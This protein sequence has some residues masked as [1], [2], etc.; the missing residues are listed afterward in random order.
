[1]KGFYIEITNNLLETKHRKAMKES[2]WLFMWLLDK[3]T[4]ISEEGIGKV[5]GGKPITYEEINKELGISRPTYIR[6][7]ELLKKGEYIN[8]L[9]TPRGL[10]F[11]INKPKK[12]FGRDVS[13]MKQ[14]NKEKKRSD[15]SNSDSDVSKTDSEVSNSDIQYKTVSKTIN[16]DNNKERERKPSPAEEMKTF[17]EGKES[18]FRLAELIVEKSGMSMEKVIREL[19]NFRGYWSEKNKSGTKQ[20]WELE[21]TFELKRRL[22][23]WFRNAE[24]FSQNKQKTIII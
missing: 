3:M 19:N 14:H 8:T 15:V 4:S 5:L 16:K 22:A 24:K 17:L 12:R 20:R 18:S 11:S 7:V 21:K 23:T 2:V 13:K 10:V 9:R 1:M 6:W